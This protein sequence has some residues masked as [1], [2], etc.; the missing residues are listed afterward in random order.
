MTTTIATRYRRIK[1]DGVIALTT[2][3]IIIGAIMMIDEAADLLR[4]RLHIAH[5]RAF[6]QGDCH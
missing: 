2:T 3:I 4:Q 6:L 5:L 1:E